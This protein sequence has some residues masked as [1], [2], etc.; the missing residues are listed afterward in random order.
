MFFGSHVGAPSQGSGR[1]LLRLG[2]H[3]EKE[4]RVSGVRGKGEGGR[5]KGRGDNDVGRRVGSVLSLRGHSHIVGC[6]VFLHPR[7]EVVSATRGGDE[8][9]RGERGGRGK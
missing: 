3:L 1:S 4:R 6:R 2:V 8:A 5:G 9:T 7:R